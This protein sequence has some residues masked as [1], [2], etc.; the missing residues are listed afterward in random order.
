MKTRPTDIPAEEFI[1]TVENAGRR[2]DAYVMLELMTRI[3]G[4]KAVMWGPSIIGFGQYRYRRADG[5]EHSFPVSG[6]SPRKAN[7]VVYLM[8]GVQQY[9]DTLAKMGK[10]KNSSSCLYLPRLKTLDLTVLEG[11]ICQ[12]IDNMKS[13]YEVTI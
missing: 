6:F 2:E 12:D 9:A 4:S 3:T 13:K 8:S 10:Y 7:L 1:Q 5:S 11:V